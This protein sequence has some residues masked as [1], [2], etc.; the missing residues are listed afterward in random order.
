MIT[1][2]PNVIVTITGGTGPA[3]VYTNIRTTRASV[4]QTPANGTFSG[5]GAHAPQPLV[6]A[7]PFDDPPPMPGRDASRLHAELGCWE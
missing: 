6:N 3:H 2:Q 7:P 4:A 1:I 5:N